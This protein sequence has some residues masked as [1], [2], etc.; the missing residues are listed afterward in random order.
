MDSL[1]V[2]FALKLPIKEENISLIYYYFQY[3]HWL[4]PFSKTVSFLLKFSIPS[5][6]PISPC[7]LSIRLIQ[8]L[9]PMEK[10]VTE[11]RVS[12]D[13]GGHLRASMEWTSPLKGYFDI[14]GR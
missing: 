8:N 5:N 9:K 12:R 13:E 2:V 7:H 10:D 6:L 11:S 14:M 3:S 1:E 4:H